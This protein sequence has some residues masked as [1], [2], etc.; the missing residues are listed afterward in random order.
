M[1]K[2]ISHIVCDVLV[3]GGGETGIRAA[4]EAKL[5]GS[6]KVLLVTKGKF[7]SA[8]VMFSEITYGWDMQAAT[9]QNDPT[10]NKQVHLDDIMRAAQ[11]TCSKK[12]AQILTE[13]SPSRLDDLQKLFELELYKKPDGTAR[14]V[15]GC[16]SSKDRGY[17]IVDP[18]KIKRNVAAGIDRYGVELIDEV[19]ITDL[20][21]T[22]GVCAG[23]WGI[24]RDG[25]SI[26]IHAGAV[27]LAAGGATGMF[28]HNFASPGMC[29]D[30]YALALRAGC[31]LVNME[32]MQFGLGLLKPKYRGLFLDRLM[33]LHPKV[34]FKYDHGFPC[35]ID[36][37]MTIHSQH[38]PF[39]TID[40]SYLFDV[41]VFDETLKNGGT[42]VTVDLSVIPIEKL[43]EIPVWKLYYEYFDK[44]NDP[45]THKL[46][47][48][49]F[50]HACNGGV[51]IDENAFSGVP[52]LFAAGEMITGPHGANRLGGNMHAACQVFGT[53]AGANAAKFAKAHPI[54][55][56]DS[57][58]ASAYDEM[59][60]DGAAKSDYIGAMREI[61]SALWEN[62]NV[63]RSEQG[64]KKALGIV[65]A[66]A[67]LLDKGAPTSD[68]LWKYYELRNTVL[69][70]EAI[71]RSALEREETRGSHF[72]IDY[73]DTDRAV[74]LV[75]CKMKNGKL[76][77]CRTG[78][79]EE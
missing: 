67:E 17:Q 79:Y 44:D 32:F 77:V 4:I 48:T 6:D 78:S 3:I 8:G 20:I 29:G 72:R 61:S 54:A 66:G 53:R 39:S 40:V 33:Y 35:S 47:I 56:T 59:T 15:F 28:K 22:D 23:A 50:A 46:E 42:G 12:M 5:R 13:E 41:A 21:I 7:G 27:V 14:Q 31:K 1:R 73:P 55:S 60:G 16:F 74:Y 52:G 26:C 76:N 49:T 62:V 38:F 25:T 51:K 68:A 9:G 37:M 18:D 65:Q 30:G 11:G 10:D 75:Q 58:A 45:Y 63:A 57:W 69:A 70:S 71:I 2:D 19:M 43:Q 34:E 36:E 64:L 24:K